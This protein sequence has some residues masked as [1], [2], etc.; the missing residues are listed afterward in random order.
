M[1][2]LSLRNGHGKE[3]GTYG[4]V[5]YYLYSFDRGRDSLP[6]DL[7]MVGSKK[8]GDNQPED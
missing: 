3:V 8:I 2:V 6:L 7:Q 1:H 5:L 4:G